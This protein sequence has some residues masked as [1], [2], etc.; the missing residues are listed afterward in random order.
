MLSQKKVFNQTGNLREAAIM[1]KTTLLLIDIKKKDADSL[2]EL[3][4][5]HY[6]IERAPFSKAAQ[7]ISAPVP[8]ACIILECSDN[9]DASIKRL[10]KIEQQIPFA[11]IPIIVLMKNK[12]ADTI[13]TL[14]DNSAADYLIKNHF[15]QIDLLQTIRKALE[16]STMQKLI[17]EKV[18]RLEEADRKINFFMANVADIVWTLDENL[19]TTSA[20]SSIEKILGI[21]PE[22][23]KKQTLEEIMTPESLERVTTRFSDE[24]QRENKKETD[25]ERIINIEIEY[26]H[27]DGHTVWT[28]NRIRILRD[29]KGRFTGIYGASRDIT[30]HRRAQEALERSEEQYRTLFEGAPVGMF[31]TSLDGSRVLAVNQKLSD[32]FGVDRKDLL[33]S[34][35]L[36][37]WANPDD[38]NEMTRKLSRDG[39]TRDYEIQIISAGDKIKTV[40]LSATLNRE[41]DWLEGTIVD[42]TKRKLTEDLLATEKRRLADILEG[43]NVGTW[44]WDIEINSVTFNDRWAEIIGYTLNELSPVSLNTWTKFC[45]P[46]DLKKSDKLLKKHLKGEIAYYEC[47][48]RMQH[49][50]GHWVWVLDRGKVTTR[51]N[52]GSPLFMSGTHQDITEQKKIEETALNASKAKSEFL[53]RMSHEIRT[54]LNAVIGMTDMALMTWDDEEQ[55]QYLETI[56]HSG[57]H[58][59]QIINDILDFSK[60]ESGKLLLE[61]EEFHLKNLFITIK[62]FFQSQIKS[63]NL[64]FKVQLADNLPQRIIADELRL[65][66]IMINLVSNAL[67]FTDTGGITIKVNL[68]NCNKC[69][70][71]ICPVEISVTDTGCG[72]SQEAQKNIFTKFEQAEKGTAR[73]YGGTGLGLSIVKEL[74]KL[75]HGQINFSSTLDQGSVFTFSIPI[76]PADSAFKIPGALAQKKPVIPDTRGMRI[77]LAEDNAINTVLAVTVLKKLEFKVTAA[78]NGLEALELIEKNKFDLVLMD[79]E[80]PRMDGI[81]ATRLI[82]AGRC[83]STASRLPVIAMTAHALTDVRKE[84]FDAGMNDYITKPI[85]ILKLKEIIETTLMETSRHH[86]EEAPPPPKDPP[87]PE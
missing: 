38:R 60:I 68:K 40:L 79:I 12:N 10:K 20:S 86:D 25:P 44:E 61:E 34:N 32:I 72:I 75:M 9:T 76:R 22:E 42:I 78:T 11:Y 47:E 21:T 43:T 18:T 67:K 84:A 26:F 73:K 45:H 3:L 36:I 29:S 6:R 27:A 83:G 66:Q 77:L 56:K 30:E 1:K 54:P 85:N 50:E 31:R 33:S 49:K 55:N 37:R 69:T 16:K 24:F 15:D 23:R 65:R 2:S 62:D 39:E 74:V 70:E 63:K 57:N 53:A 71:G 7:S 81:E 58:L 80:M 28:D 46:D 52:E 8:P 48:A 41:K 13:T 82:R 87:P 35:A 64:S 5:R 17:A 59:L 14:L 4:D 19:Q 51:D